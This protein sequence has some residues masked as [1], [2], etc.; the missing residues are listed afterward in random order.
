MPEMYELPAWPDEVYFPS[1]GTNGAG[2]G[3]A[4]FVDAEFV[5]LLPPV[6]PLCPI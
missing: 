2:M 3:G 4:N 5:S 6:V 1:H